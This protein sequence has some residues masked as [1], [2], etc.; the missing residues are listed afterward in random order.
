MSSKIT[1][2]EAKV[3]EIHE[4]LKSAK[5]AVLYDY[6]G[7]TVEEVTN[8]RNE[9]RSAGV[10]YKVLKNSLVERAADEI[11]LTDLKSYLSGPTA[12]AF[13]V[14]DP[15]APARI[16][17]DFIKK[18]KKTAIKGGVVEG[19]V[20][21]A[22]GVKALADLPSREVLI[23]NV[24]RTMNAPITGFV[25]VLSGTMRNLLYA[26]NAVKEKKEA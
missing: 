1:E 26:L 2:K 19:K 10:A 3:A 24:L 21:D 22:N 12:I 4:A 18:V 7:L 6:R 23:T 16:L 11:G 8:L 15:V 5:G 17:T 25:T 20:I 14:K 13:C 9:A